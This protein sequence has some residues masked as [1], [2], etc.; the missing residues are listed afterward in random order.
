LYPADGNAPVNE[1]EAKKLGVQRC[2]ILSELPELLREH[3]VAVEPLL[4]H[5]GFVVEDF[6]DVDKP[7]PFANVV[8]LLDDCARATDQGQFGLLLGLR[9]RTQHLGVIGEMVRNAPT[10]GR[11][12]RNFV[13]NHHRYVRGGAPYVVEQDPYLVRHKDELLVGYRCMIRSLPSIQF[14]LASIGAGVSFIREL[15]GHNPSQVLIGCSA[16]LLPEEELRTLLKPSRVRFESHHFGIT[17]PKTVVDA[18]V[19]RADPVKYRAALEAVQGYWNAVEPDLVDQV[20]RLLMPVLLAERA[21]MQFLCEST[22]LHARTINRRL[23]DHG[24]NLRT[25]VND[26]RFDVACQ[27][28]KH[29]D[30]PVATVAEVMGYSEPS[31]FSRAFRQWSGSTPD[32][33]RKSLLARA[34]EAAQPPARL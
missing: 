8:R 19:L 18:P 17:Y 27:L 23:K 28:L 5:R 2:G 11:A 26:A 25:L 15:T 33:W 16:Q 13:E 32:N 20:R 30:L 3:G 9:A 10:L 31:V 22:Q 12:I 1:E 4:Q 34:A 14:L 29:T 7:L 6:E 24:T 21:H